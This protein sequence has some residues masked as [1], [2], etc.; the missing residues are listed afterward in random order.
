MSN[1]C[2][3]GLSERTGCLLCGDIV[4]WPESIASINVRLT[5][6]HEFKLRQID[7]NRKISRRVDE[8]QNDQAKVI[9]NCVDRINVL[10]TEINTI[11]ALGSGADH[12]K[13]PHKCPIC[14]GRGQVQLEILKI[15]FCLSC[16]G[17][18]IIWG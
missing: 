3:H 2:K 13:K 8:I 15:S 10:Q 14:D 16:D 4:E 9:N 18:G 5:A 17:K 11:R 1:L 6:L 12:P 7:E